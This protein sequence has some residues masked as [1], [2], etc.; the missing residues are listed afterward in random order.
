MLHIPYGFAT[1]MQGAVGMAWAAYG[2]ATLP[3]KKAETQQQAEQQA[4]QQQQQQ[5]Q[6]GVRLPQLSGSSWQQIGVL[7]YAHAVMG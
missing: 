4:E 7:C 3:R 1:C 2:A 6:Q 5:Q